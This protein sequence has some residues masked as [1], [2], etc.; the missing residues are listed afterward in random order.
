MA[1]LLGIVIAVILFLV[2]LVLMTAIV[3]ALFPS[4]PPPRFRLP[5]PEDLGERRE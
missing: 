1:T 3:S 4:R 2:V 5:A